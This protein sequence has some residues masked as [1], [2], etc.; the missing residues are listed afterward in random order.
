MGRILVVL[1]F[2][3]SHVEAY[4]LPLEYF[5]SREWSG[6]QWLPRLNLG[7]GTA[8]HIYQKKRDGFPSPRDCYSG[9]FILSLR[10]YHR[11]H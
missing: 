11:P 9:N 10:R 8:A 2:L 5:L 3:L 7:H 1:P 6:C 4:C